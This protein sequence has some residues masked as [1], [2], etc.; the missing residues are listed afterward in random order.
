MSLA[1]EGVSSRHWA[2]TGLSFSR[3]VALVNQRPPPPEGM[4]MLLPNAG[5]LLGTQPFP[6]A[7][8]RPAG[9]ALHY[10]DLEKSTPG[11][12]RWRRSDSALDIPVCLHPAL[13]PF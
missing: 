12:Y 13:I 8:D 5:I 10:W 2:S 7:A 4:L 9:D 1:L 3:E 6:E 11:V